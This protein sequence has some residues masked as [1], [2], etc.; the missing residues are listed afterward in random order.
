MLSNRGADLNAR[1]DRSLTPLSITARL[2]NVEF[3]RM[4]LERGAVI[5]SRRSFGRTALYLE[6]Y[7]TAVQWFFS[8]QK[9][10]TLPGQCPDPKNA[11]TL[12]RGPL[13]IGNLAHA[14]SVSA[15][16]LSASWTP[17]SIRT[18]KPIQ[19]FPFPHS[20]PSERKILNN[21]WPPCRQPHRQHPPLFPTSS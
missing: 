14:R 9:S 2:K 16:A 4:L 21:P 5:N 1:D 15:F 20:L 12:P 13:A 7:C 18:L 6:I 10:Q 11:V 19:P 8:S 17:P 3:A